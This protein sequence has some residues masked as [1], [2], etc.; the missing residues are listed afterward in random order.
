VKRFFRSEGGFTLI[1]VG[2]SMGILA[3]AIGALLH[4]TYLATMNNSDVRTVSQATLLVREV[5]GE[6]EYK[7]RKDGFPLSDYEGRCDDFKIKAL[8][9]A[10]IGCDYTVRK[11]ELP[12]GDILPRLMGGGGGD[13]LSD[14]SLKDQ[15]LSAAKG[16]AGTPGSPPLTSGIAPTA[17]ADIA[18]LAKGALGSNPG[19]AA[20]ALQLY[21]SQM[22]SMLEE[23]LRE[24][25]L[26][27]YWRPGPRSK[28]WEG[29]TVVTHLVDVGRAGV[30]GAD[31]ASGQISGQLGLQAPVPGQAQPGMAPGMPGVP[32]MGAPP[33]P[34]FQPL[35][36]TVNI[37]GPKR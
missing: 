6:I 8:K 32:G 31:Q 17:T 9:T 26:N 30:S 12:I 5:M 13:P 16:Q 33:M 10:G 20:N 27:M 23:A 15:L 24:V 36:P 3:I 19:L 11:V 34:G 21:A 4:G 2:M 29:F 18:S 25:R 1:E 14:P 7:L 37:L 22:E 28:E 35:P